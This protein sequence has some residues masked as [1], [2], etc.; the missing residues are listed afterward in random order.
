MAAILITILAKSIH[1]HTGGERGMHMTEL[2]LISPSSGGL[3][4]LVEVA[5]VLGLAPTEAAPSDYPP[6]LPR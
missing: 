6:A 5:C 3:Q 1:L 4:T 2:R